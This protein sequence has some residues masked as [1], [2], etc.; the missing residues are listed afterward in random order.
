[1]GGGTCDADSPQEGPGPSCGLPLSPSAALPRQRLLIASG[2]NV[3]T[4]QGRPRHASAKT[5]LDTCGHIWPDRDESTRAAIEAVI[6]ARE[7]QD[8]NGDEVVR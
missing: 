3:K 5:T 8:L 2:A 7:E 4:V 1:M 6:T